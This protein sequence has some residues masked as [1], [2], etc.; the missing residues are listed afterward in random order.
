M[1]VEEIK[2]PDFPRCPEWAGGVTYNIAL[3]GDCTLHV[4]MAGCA[5]QKAQK[6]LANELTLFANMQYLSCNKETARDITGKQLIELQKQYKALAIQAK[7][8]E[9]KHAELLEDL[10]NSS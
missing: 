5:T 3:K 1:K 10:E 9:A 7:K 2:V 6:D 4:P 8:L